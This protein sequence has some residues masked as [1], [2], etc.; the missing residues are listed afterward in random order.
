M[1][2]DDKEPAVTDTEKRPRILA[3][4]RFVRLLARRGWE[5]AERTN[6]SAAVVV[7]AVTES[8][9]LVL[10]EQYRIPLSCRV[11][12]LPAGL[13]G[14][15]A[16]NKEEGLVEAVP[17]SSWRRRAMRRHVSTA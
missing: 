6:T 14:D 17:V 15:L 2:P 3:E 12:E 5:W 11:I 4:G 8:R 13:V 9:Q 10:V 7:V 16:A 1:N